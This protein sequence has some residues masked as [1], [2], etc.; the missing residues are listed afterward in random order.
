MAK[1][2]PVVGLLLACV[3][4]FVTLMAFIAQAKELTYIAM[5]EPVQN[6]FVDLDKMVGALNREIWLFNLI[7]CESGGLADAINPNDTDGTPSYGILQFKRSTFS[8]FSKKY[9]IDGDMM[10]GV[11]EVEIVRRMMDDSSVNLHHQFP[12]C[13]RKLGLPPVN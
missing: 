5:P 2:S 13:T 11:A 1:I 9:D 4:M 8:G 12:G 7:Q 3:F 6:H 10:D